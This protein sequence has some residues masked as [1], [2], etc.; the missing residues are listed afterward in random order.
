M[1]APRLPAADRRNR[2]GKRAGR[3]A[4]GPRLVD[5]DG[6]W[7]AHGT[8]RIGQQPIRLRRSLG[9]AIRSCTQAEAETALDALVADI[10]AQTEGRARR[11]DKISHAAG[12]YL[13]LARARPLA[14]TSI[15][16]VKEIVARFRERRLNEIAAHEWREWIDGDGRTAGRMNG[17]SASTRERFLNGVVAF[18]NYCK[19]HHGLTALPAFSRDRMARNPNR[20]QRRP[21]EDLRP[22]LIWTLFINAH[23]AIRA[24]LAV[25][26]C[27]GA[28]VS[29]ILYGATVADLD[30]TAGRERIVFSR[31]KNGRD[32]AAAIDAT[33]VAVLK[34]YLAWRGPFLRRDDVLFVTPAG[35]PY[36]YRRKGGG[37]NKTGFNAAKRRAQAAVR[38]AAAV[39]AR[40]CRGRGD[41]K[42]AWAAVMAAKADASLLGRV[43]QHWFRHMLAT[44]LVRKDLRATM[45]QGGWLDPRSVMGYAFD[46]PEHRQQ[47]V[48]GLD[49]L[50]TLRDTAV[51]ENVNR[52]GRSK[53]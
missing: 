45:E 49:D 6:Y 52:A 18:L 29:S 9:L 39:K 10:K 19:R 23:I 27:T 17:R 35:R 32:V 7:H 26:R 50:D 12:S 37:Q 43:T 16:I 15:D 2:K 48:R 8:L 11:G 14:P 1:D 46:V 22:D 24:Q 44:R 13:S 41:R 53:A 33:A 47:L 25:E 3:R 5:R 4:R 34:E 21:V 42:A 20:R 38:L 36:I 30:L 40:A 51:I 28:R 31:T